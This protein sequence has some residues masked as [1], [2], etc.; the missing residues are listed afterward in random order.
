MTAGRESQII[1]KARE[2]GADLA[3]IA[4]VALLE[5]SPSHELFNRIG[6]KIDG[7][8]FAPAGFREINWPANMKSV[9]VIGVAHPQDKPELDWFEARGDSPGNK[10]LIKVN[11]ELSVWI[12][13]TF[14]IKTHKLPYWV[15]RG[16]M[17]LK[18]AG[19]L[20]GLGCVG[21]NN[22]LITPELGPRIRLRGMLLGAELTPT[23]PIDFDPC[24]ECE[25]YCRTA[26]PQK[27]FD[28]TVLASAET[29]MNALPGRDGSYSRARCIIQ[30]NHDVE[31]AGISL[32]DTPLSS[33]EGE[34]TPRQEGPIKYCRDC[35]FA[36]PVGR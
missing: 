36:C 4:S 30:I 16:G 6:E 19:V 33:V 13:E 23:G 5:Q 25:E 7:V 10:A 21:R 28:Q 17:Y 27:A 24:S 20:S 31:A 2:L 1:E 3:G 12:E 35:E 34:D 18:D 14:D 22:M 26:C 29:G 15:E 32:D 9:L 8:G 11:R